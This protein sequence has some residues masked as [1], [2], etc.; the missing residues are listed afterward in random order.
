MRDDGT[1][2]AHL[3]QPARAQ[4]CARAA[5]HTAPARPPAV[6]Q[7][8]AQALAPARRPRRAVC[9]VRSRLGGRGDWRT[10]R[11]A[12]R[13]QG[14]SRAGRRYVARRARVKPDGERRRSTGC[15][16]A[17]AVGGAVCARATRPAAMA[18]VPAARRRCGV[19]RVSRADGVARA[20]AGGTARCSSGRGRR[21]MGG[22]AAAGRVGRRTGHHDWRRSHRGRRAVAAP[23]G[24][25]QAARRAGRADL[26][27]IQRHSA[28]RGA[29]SGNARRGEDAGWPR[30]RAASRQ[31]GVARGPG[32][33]REDARADASASRARRGG[34]RATRGH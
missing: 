24:K 29:G 33:A 7:R 17:V 26:Y 2:H 32:G 12:R 14:A 6:G 21:R 31:R 18:A 22:D 11:R 27:P 20:H 8:D 15:S 25:R 19:R 9:P 1:G 28:G 23:G 34:S 5:A 30:R 3:R 4:R 16:S 13:G 10:Q